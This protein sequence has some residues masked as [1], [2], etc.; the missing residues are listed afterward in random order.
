M[1]T[2]RIHNPE[3]SP[4]GAVLAL[5]S[6]FSTRWAT[7]SVDTTLFYVGEAPIGSLESGTVWRIQKIDTTNGTVK[8]AS[9]GNFNQV[10]TNRESL[11]Y[12]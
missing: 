6:E 2:R 8:F 1:V 7:D 5:Q 4:M 3:A 10:W 11:V 12:A 9:T